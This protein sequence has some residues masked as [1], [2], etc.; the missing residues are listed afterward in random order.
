MSQ[1]ALEII[2]RRKNMTPEEKSKEAIRKRLL[3]YQSL[4]IERKKEL[5]LE[6]GNTEEDFERIQKEKKERETTK[7]PEVRYRDGGEAVYERRTFTGKSRDFEDIKDSSVHDYIT[8]KHDQ[9]EAEQSWYRIY[10]IKGPK[11]EFIASK[12]TQAGLSRALPSLARE[13]SPKGYS[14][15]VIVLQTIDLKDYDIVKDELV[16]ITEQFTLQNTFIDQ[17]DSLVATL[18]RQNVNLGNMLQDRSDISDNYKLQLDKVA[19]E[20][21]KKKSSSKK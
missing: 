14:A 8:E 18:K 3:I 16:A 19:R 12:P 10:A 17:Q 5:Y 15:L 7:K 2:E 20:N 6:S 4:P 1:R 21:E 13:L 11:I 9:L